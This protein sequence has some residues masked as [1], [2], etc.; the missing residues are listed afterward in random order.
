MLTIA[1]VRLP[2]NKHNT[3]L[4]T[5]HVSIKAYETQDAKA[6]KEGR[7]RGRNQSGMDSLRIKILEG[8]KKKHL[9]YLPHT[10]DIE[11]TLQCALTLG[12]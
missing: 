1:L 10:K 6:K 2:T 9:R 12:K 3:G 8:G 4:N 7:E 11:E 5:D